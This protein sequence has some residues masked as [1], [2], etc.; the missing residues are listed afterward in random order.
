MHG[1]S[2]PP[3]RARDRGGSPAVQHGGPGERDVRQPQQP[4]RRAALLVHQR[5]EGGQA[6]TP[7]AGGRFK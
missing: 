5:R 2:A 1:F 4:P 7:H 3:W 6:G